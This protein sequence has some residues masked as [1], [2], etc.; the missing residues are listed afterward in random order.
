MNVVS[1]FLKFKKNILYEYITIFSPK[2]NDKFSKEIIERLIDTYFKTYY[3]HTLETLESQNKY[4]FNVI[5][6]EL[7]G[8]FLEIVY[9]LND[10]SK[11]D[12]INDCYVGVVTACTFDYI[13][14]E[15][16][17]D[18][19]KEILECNLKINIDESTIETLYDKIQSNKNKVEKFTDK[20]ISEEFFIDY[21]PYRDKENKFK[22]ELKT[23]IS[24]LDKYPQFSLEKNLN[25]DIIADEKLK[26][27]L[28]LLSSDIL[29]RMLS[30]ENID[31]YFVDLP[32]CLLESKDK[33]LSVISFSDNEYINKHIIFVVDFNDYQ[34]RKRAVNIADQTYSFAAIVDMSHIRE[35]EQKLE[36]VEAIPVFDYIIVDKL[37]DK[38]Y[39]IVFK[40]NS[41]SSKE[42]IINESIKE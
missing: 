28:N 32:F 27:T 36:V 33:L 12:I 5:L 9:E 4:N 31:Y 17:L 41:S 14:K 2:L 8:K 1:V 15:I 26:L 23:K 19:I 24:S 6:E 20:I 16:N 3:F 25:S 13:K 42:I 35:V 21:H 11:I 34:N 22:I 30:S 18:L 39:G 7:K 40:Y 10:K 29:F 37:K 38:D